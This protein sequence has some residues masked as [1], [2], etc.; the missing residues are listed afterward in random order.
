MNSNCKW[1][2]GGEEFKCARNREILLV[3]HC[4][5]REEDN[6]RVLKMCQIQSRTI[7]DP[8]N[9]LYTMRFYTNLCIFF[10]DA[11]VFRDKSSHLSHFCIN[12]LGW[13]PPFIV[14]VDTSIEISELATRNFAVDAALA[15]KKIEGTKTLQ[16]IDFFHTI[17]D[18]W[19]GHIGYAEII[20]CQLMSGWKVEKTGRDL[21]NR[22]GKRIRHMENGGPI[23]G[24]IRE[25]KSVLV[26][27]TWGG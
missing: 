18:F 23:I 22:F 16:F 7:T 10:G 19:W 21:Q 1:L 14:L 4:I 11:Q 3:H 5:L 6:W 26:M 2:T 20:E 27:E 12:L 24:K 25:R 15:A 13:N 9:R 8:R 17:L